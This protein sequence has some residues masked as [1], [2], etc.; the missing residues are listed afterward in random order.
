M[1]SETIV[2]NICVCVLLHYITVCNW[3][4]FVHVIR[5]SW[6]TGGIVSQQPASV[7]WQG[8]G[9][10]TLQGSDLFFHSAVQFNELSS[11]SSVIYSFESEFFLTICFIFMS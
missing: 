3:D 6:F 1:I 7:R 5:E 11:G 2:F 8:D 9:S 4:I 10:E